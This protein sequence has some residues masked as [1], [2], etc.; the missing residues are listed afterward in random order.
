LATNLTISPA[1]GT[2]NDLAAV[3]GSQSNGWVVSLRGQGRGL[4]QE[5]DVPG[6]RELQ[7]TTPFGH[8]GA[9]NYKH[10][11]LARIVH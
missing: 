6:V 11:N 5:G 4:N 7:I 2:T 9:G 3:F 1:D 8:K 10:T